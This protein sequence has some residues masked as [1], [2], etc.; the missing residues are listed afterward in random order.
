MTLAPADQLQAAP[1]PPAP[2][3]EA[4]PT[5]GQPSGPLY[6]DAMLR[7]NRSL[8]PTGFVVVMG[9]LT[10]VSFVAGVA[11]TL[12]GAWPVFGFFGLDVALVYLAF[13]RNYY[14]GRLT[15]TVRLDD[16]TLEVVRTQP[17]GSARR[18]TFQ[19]YWLRLTEPDPEREDSQIIL[20]SHGRRLIIGSF[21]APEER[22]DLA[23]ALKLALARQHAG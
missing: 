10:L 15:E 20:S 7:P 23:R 21:L 18:W 1:A 14:S 8:G 13:R 6:F 22:I 3:T 9:I 4:P 17:D 11:F 12:M 16:T 19:P 5:E 2:S